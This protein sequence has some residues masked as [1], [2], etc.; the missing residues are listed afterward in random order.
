MS[1]VCHACVML[2][3]LAA[4]GI[5]ATPGSA[6]PRSIA[7]TP[8]PGAARQ[9]GPPAPTPAPTTASSSSFALDDSRGRL[10]HD[11]EV[12][13]EQQ[14]GAED[15]GIIRTITT[16]VRLFLACVPRWGPVSC[17]K[18]EALLV[19]HGEPGDSVE[20]FVDG[21]DA[22]S[23]RGSF[24]S[25]LSERP[26]ARD[27]YLNKMLLQAVEDLLDDAL[28][29]SRGQAERGMRRK[30]RRWPNPLLAVM[31]GLGSLIVVG[32]IAKT[33]MIAGKA[34]A[35]SLLA[36]ALAVMMGLRGGGGGGGG[37]AANYEILAT[38]IR[39]RTGLSGAV[40]YPVYVDAAEQPASAGGGQSLAYSG[41]H[42]RP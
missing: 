16:Q 6:A 27:A 19:L 12:P 37:G 4:R 25:E 15:P 29:L 17:L 2:A 34:L 10:G 35:L 40:Q 32:G 42:T 8:R 14:L 9:L 11:E 41:H 21:P 28:G 13:E 20:G 33:A 36:L 39:R 7:L 24:F 3:V 31:F 38:G 26:E 5:A 22:A 1:G 18:L 23:R 30:G